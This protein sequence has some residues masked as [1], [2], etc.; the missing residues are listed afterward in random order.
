[1]GT[2][3]FLL[4]LQLNVMKATESEVLPHV[5]ETA[6]KENEKGSCCALEK[7]FKSLFKLHKVDCISIS[8]TWSLIFLMC[9]PQ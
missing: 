7:I 5:L 3:A 2:I 6:W 4:V 8:S 9:V 1:M